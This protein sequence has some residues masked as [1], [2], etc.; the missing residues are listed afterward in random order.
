MTIETSKKVLSEITRKYFRSNV[1][2]FFGKEN[3]DKVCDQGHNIVGISGM[4]KDEIIQFGQA[5]LSIA[6]AENVIAK[7]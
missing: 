3:I 1:A 2:E 5:L 4:S 6:D 7:V